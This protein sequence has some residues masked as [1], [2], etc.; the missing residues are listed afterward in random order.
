MVA[1]RFPRINKAQETLMNAKYIKKMRPLET[2]FRYGSRNKIHEAIMEFT[3][4]EKQ[5]VAWDLGGRSNK[6][7][8][9]LNY[10]ILL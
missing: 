1:L 2:K 9:I 8:D 5:T 6:L 4:T 3:D 10:I 7:V